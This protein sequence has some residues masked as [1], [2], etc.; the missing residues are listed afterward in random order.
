MSVPT[1]YHPTFSLVM[2]PNHKNMSQG[3]NLPIWDGS[4]ADPIAWDNYRYAIQ[5]Y[6]A[7]KGLLALLK[8]TYQPA[9]KEEEDESD[10]ELQEMLLGILLQTTRDV[11]GM[12]V[13]PF[14]EEGDGVGAWRALISGY[15]NDSVQLRQARQIEY[16][17]ILEDVCCNSRDKILD[18]VHMVE[19]LFTELDK[20]D[21]I[22]PES[23]KKKLFYS[24]LRTRLLRYI[25]QLHKI[26]T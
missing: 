6:C 16:Q 13:R 12:V 20:L 5:G 4:S 22:L 18:T 23:Y 10:Q 25:L 14:T 24:R 8:R 15:G 17:K 3:S 19:H 1:R 26:Q 2:S 7:G 9:E 21:C 11:A